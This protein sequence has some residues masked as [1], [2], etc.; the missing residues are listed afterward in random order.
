MTDG[1]LSTMPLPF[2]YTSVLAVPRSIARSRATRT[3]L[4]RVVLT[5]RLLVGRRWLPRLVDGLAA[6][7]RVLD[8][9][10]GRAPRF[11]AERVD[12]SAE[13]VDAVRGAVAANE[14]DGDHHD[15][16]HHQQDDD[17]PHVNGPRDRRWPHRP[18]RSA[19]ERWWPIRSHPP[20]P[21]ASIQE[22]RP[23]RHRSRTGRR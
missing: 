18:R 23:S 19:P 14:E 13:R 20:R 6:R 2:M 21:R 1:S 8:L 12:V 16:D 4:V 9:V 15:D 10:D 11:R 22:R 5:G 17:E 7:S 3:A